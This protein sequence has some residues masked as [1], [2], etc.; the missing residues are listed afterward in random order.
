MGH[1]KAW[2]QILTSHFRF[3]VKVLLRVNR[4]Q[5]ISPT[6][7]FK[8]HE[9]QNNVVSWRCHLLNTLHFCQKDYFKD[10]VCKRYILRL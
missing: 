1:S 2:V 9:S 5:L 3:I 8:K 10:E 7:A 6:K 4:E